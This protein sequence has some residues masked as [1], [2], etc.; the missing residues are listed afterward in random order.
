MRLKRMVIASENPAEQIRD[1]AFNAEGLSLIVDLDSKEGNSGNNI[2]KS[3]F[4]KIID[5]CLG[6]ESVKT[7]YHDVETKDDDLVKSHLNNARVYAVLTVADG[8]G[9][10]H[11][12]R[13]DLWEGGKCQLDGTTFEK[14]KDYRE[15]I[16]AIAFPDASDALTLRQIMPFFLRLENTQNYI[17]EYLGTYH[18]SIEYRQYYDYLIGAKSASELLDLSSEIKRKEDQN[19]KILRRYGIREIGQLDKLIESAR[20]EAEEKQKEFKSDDVVLG[21]AHDE[22]NASLE[23]DLNAKT[24]RVS[25]TKGEIA[26][27]KEKV[28][29]E[30]DTIEKIDRQALRLLY[31]DGRMFVKDMNKD[32]DEFVAFHQEMTRKRLDGFE[33]RIHALEE[34]LM[35]EEKE[36]TEARKSYA[37]RF[38]DYKFDLNG[39]ENDNLR[40]IIDVCYRLKSLENDRKAY[41]NN[42]EDISRK[43]AELNEI[44]LEKKKLKERRKILNSAFRDIT[45]RVFGAPFELEFTKDLGAFPIKCSGGNKGAGDRKTIVACFV[46]SMMKLYE[47]EKREMPFFFVQD[48]MEGVSLANLEKL[49]KEAKSAR[50][51]YIIPILSDRARSLGDLDKKKVLAL[52]QKDKLFKL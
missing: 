23:E 10:E 52:S 31:E 21:F 22:G 2:G 44:Q 29:H 42:K 24:Q 28:S 5:L 18:R 17:F 15:K 19:S 14:K 13:R 50:C 30:R 49:E 6:A 32:F 33:A 38:V 34:R 25:D 7:I 12:L 48:Q 40:E 47:K 51:Q 11:N 3:T 43:Q 8:K 4:A 37:S 36:L 39:K 26:F 46:F 27:L 20:K 16:K 35:K 41:E 45:T 1:V 9:R